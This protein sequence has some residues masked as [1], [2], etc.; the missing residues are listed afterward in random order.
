MVTGINQESTNC[1]I[2]DSCNYKV[3]TTT[4]QD[5]Q[6]IHLC[7]RIMQDY[8]LARFLTLQDFYFAR[9]R[10]KATSCK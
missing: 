3:I 1:M 10:H 7:T 4:L 6:A 2:Q 9:L 8:V 5:L